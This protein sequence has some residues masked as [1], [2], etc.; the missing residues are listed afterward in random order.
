MAKNLMDRIAASPNKFQ[1]VNARIFKL[2]DVKPTITEIIHVD[3]GM[4]IDQ[5]PLNLLHVAFFSTLAR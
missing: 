3:T 1:P 4:H 2:E 5:I